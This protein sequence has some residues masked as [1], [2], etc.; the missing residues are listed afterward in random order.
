MNQLDIK[1]Y[2][3]NQGVGK[4]TYTLVTPY[5]HRIYCIVI[6]WYTHG[7]VG[8]VGKNAENS[9]YARTR[10]RENERIDEREYLH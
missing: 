9:V 5:L 8:G 4:F 6:Q 3:D 1:M 10:A 2:I 7:G